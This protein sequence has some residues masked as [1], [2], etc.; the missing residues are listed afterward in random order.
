MPSTITLEIESEAPGVLF[1]RVLAA[2]G[3]PAFSSGF[4][5]YA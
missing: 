3:E 1:F 4:L 5:C 2:T